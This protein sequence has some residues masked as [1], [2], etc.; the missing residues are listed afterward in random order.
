MQLF[1]HRGI[2]FQCFSSY[3]LLCQTLFFQAAPLLPPVT[4]QQNAMEYW[5]EGST[6]TAIPP[7]SASEVMGQYIKIAGVTIG[8]ALI[9][10][11]S[12]THHIEELFLSSA[13]QLSSISSP[14]CS[15]PLSL[16]K[17]GSLYLFFLT[18]L[19]V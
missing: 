7:T 6:S 15:S 3:T 19:P 11:R 17:F 14:L 10:C 4:W 12:L 5:W 16:L 18:S 2:Q 1:L 13:V 9:L 8:A